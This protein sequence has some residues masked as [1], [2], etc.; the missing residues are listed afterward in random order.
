MATPVNVEGSFTRRFLNEK[1]IY[2]RL[3][4]RAA[5]TNERDGIGKKRLNTYGYAENKPNVIIE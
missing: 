3:K 4:K 1:K 2:I 5:V